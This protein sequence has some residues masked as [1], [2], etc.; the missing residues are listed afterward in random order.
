MAHPGDVLRDVLVGVHQH[1]RLVSPAARHVV[2]DVTAACAWEKGGGCQKSTPLEGK[3]GTGG[4]IPRGKTG[5][6][7]ERT[8]LEV[9]GWFRRA[10]PK[11][12]GGMVRRADPKRT[13]RW[14]RSAGSS[15]AVGG[16]QLERANTRSGRCVA[17][18]AAL[19]HS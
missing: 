10:H 14:R 3:G 11:R 7:Q 16:R 5:W 17:G 4:Q 19:P 6:G 8:P 18:D 2:L 12:G 15:R 1:R 9:K 13:S